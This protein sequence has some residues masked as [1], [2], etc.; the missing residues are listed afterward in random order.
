MPVNANTEKPALDIEDWD[1]AFEAYDEHPN[2][3]MF[4]SV[5]LML[6]KSCISVKP[7]RIQE[8]IEGLDNAMEALFDHTDFREVSYALFVRLIGGKLPFEQQEMLKMLGVKF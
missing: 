1:I 2:A 6:L 5:N 4:L 7:L 3:A 8:A